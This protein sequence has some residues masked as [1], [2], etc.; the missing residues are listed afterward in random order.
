MGV[1]L[2]CDEPIADE[3]H[4]RCDLSGPCLVDVRV[5]ISIGKECRM[6]HVGCFYC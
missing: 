1:D 6:R 5:A 3:C 2:T 4:Y